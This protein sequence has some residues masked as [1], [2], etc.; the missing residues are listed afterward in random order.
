MDLNHLHLHVADTERSL[1]FYGRYFGFR[2]HVRHGEL[3]FVRNERDFDLALA[4]ADKVE[5]FPKWFHFGFRLESDDAVKALH[6]R[7]KED[8]LEGL[9]DLHDD[10]DLVTFRCRDPD[11]YFIEVYWE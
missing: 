11:G 8:G 7:M 5:T 2:E 9:G 4:P 3:L 6:T 10:S 1:G